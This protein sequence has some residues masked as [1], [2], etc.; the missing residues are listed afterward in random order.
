MGRQ[1]RGAARRQDGLGEETTVLALFPFSANAAIVRNRSAAAGS[2]RVLRVDPTRSAVRPEISQGGPPAPTATFRAV[3]V[4]SPAVRLPVSLEGDAEGLRLVR[5]A[6]GSS[7]DVYPA[8]YVR[9]TGPGEPARLL[10]RADDDRYSIR[11]PADGRLLVQPLT[12]FDASARL[13]VR[14]LEQIAR[15]HLTLD[16]ANDS[17]A[18]PGDAVEF[19]V[20]VDGR[21][22]RGPE[23]RLTYRF[24]GGKWRQPTFRLAVRNQSP[25]RLY[26]ALV[27]LSDDWQI[28]AD[29]FPAGG[30]WIEPG[31]QAW[32]LDGQPVYASVP[33]ELW[34]RGVTEFRDRVLA[35]VSNR[36][37]DARPLEQP[38][39][40]LPRQDERHAAGT[41][42]KGTLQHLL[43]QTGSR[44]GWS[45][46]PEEIDDW[47]V[48]RTVLTTV[49]PLDAVEMPA[50]PGQRSPLI[51][52][53]QVE[54][55]TAFRG[56]VQLLTAAQAGDRTPAP[57]LPTDDPAAVAPFHPTPTR[58]SGPEANLLE[59]TAEDAP[60]AVTP[61]DP[62]RFP[63]GSSL[64]PDEQ[65]LALA[66]DGEFWLPVGRS[67]FGPSGEPQ[68]VVSTLI[69]PGDARG[70]EKRTVGGAYRMY[71]YKV[72]GKVFRYAASTGR[73]AQ[74]VRDTPG[75]FAYDDHKETIRQQIHLRGRSCSTSTV[76]SGTRTRCCRVS[77]PGPPFRIGNSSAATYDVVLAFDY[78]NLNT[79]ISQTARAEGGAG[80][81]GAG[82][83]SWQTAGRG[84]AFD[85]R[86]GVALADRAGEGRPSYRQPAGDA[87]HSQRRL[88]VADRPFAGD[89]GPDRRRERRHR[90]AGEDLPGLH[91]GAR[92][93]RRHDG[94]DESGLAPHRRPLRPG[95]PRGAL[96]PGGGQHVAA[97]RPERSGPGASGS[98]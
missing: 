4:E 81:G 16:L 70:E 35:I 74:V 87:G 84:G 43:A 14:Q 76:S 3:I 72:G 32:A 13:A 92:R 98:G 60:D 36:E 26:A 93:P 65:L 20:E 57:L 38:K 56:R 11:R 89:D 1:R 86:A 54:G 48:V 64:D 88:A 71:L 18:L 85:G 97:R 27:T 96:R 66:H 80:G 30:A 51:G 6:L 52:G 34:D 59:I 17:G 53:M 47:Q 24:D 49:R 25:Y 75:L 12:G 10:L 91:R 55:H 45:A 31:S 33:K 2:A 90:R 29:L 41:V 68:L 67:E 83:R 7:E 21:P 77:G 23:H 82:G 69:A 22:S 8:L 42:S 50:G 63:L 44:S 28:R 79:P 58:G 94:A 37:F 61:D 46:T 78:E 73:L 9:E 39:L 40:G 15:W 5:E 95:Q 19:L 62:L